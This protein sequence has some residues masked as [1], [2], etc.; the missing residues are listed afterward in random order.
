MG[1]PVVAVGAR[2]T[3]SGVAHER[4]GYLVTPGDVNALIHHS[5]ELLNDP[6]LWARLSAGARSFGAS[7]TPHGVAQRV[8]DVYSHV[9]GMPRAVAF[10]DDLSGHPRSSLAYDQ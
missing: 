6:A 5:R 2:G 10:Q 7:T 3:L 8:L 9:L 1:V 4:S